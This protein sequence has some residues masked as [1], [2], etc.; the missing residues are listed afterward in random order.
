MT[1]GS[2]RTY[3][4]KPPKVK[5]PRAPKEPETIISMAPA[6]KRIAPKQRGMTETKKSKIYKKLL[7]NGFTEKEALKMLPRILKEKERKIGDKKKTSLQQ[8][9]D[10]LKGKSVSTTTSDLPIKR[11]PQ[12]IQQIHF[13]NVEE[14]EK[15]KRRMSE[16]DLPKLPQVPDSIKTKGAFKEWYR[17][18]FGVKKVPKSLSD[19]YDDSPKKKVGRPKKEKSAKERIKENMKRLENKEKKIETETRPFIRHLERERER[20]EQK[21][22]HFG[23]PPLRRTQSIDMGTEDISLP[24]LR[25][26][27]SIDMGTDGEGSGLS[28]DLYTPVR[29]NDNYVGTVTLETNFKKSRPITLRY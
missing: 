27:Q 5:K 26:T 16:T 17:A 8:L 2:G 25:R 15:P 1:T 20:K 24:P 4:R 19:V 28:S 6:P 9:I 13:G 11:K 12:P 29:R 23:A 3:M 14:K 21:E 18:T 22:E 7:E 10:V